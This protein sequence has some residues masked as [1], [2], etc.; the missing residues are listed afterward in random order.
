LRQE[1]TPVRGCVRRHLRQIAR[2]AYGNAVE[3]ATRPHE[4]WGGIVDT[5]RS[6]RKLHQ[7]AR[8]AGAQVVTG[9]DPDVWPKFKHAPEFYD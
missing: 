9:H 2:D 6:V 7:V 8:R 1:S 3:C 4:H 5:V